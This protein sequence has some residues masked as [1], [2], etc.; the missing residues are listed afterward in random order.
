MTEHLEDSVLNDGVNG[1]RDAINFLQSLRAM[2]SGDSKSSK[3]NVTTK[4]DGAPAIFAGIN[5][6]NGKFFV[7]TKGV[8]AQNAKLNYTN[9]DIDANHPSEGLAS[10]LKLA[11][12][13]LAELN[14]KGVLQGDMMYARS[15]LKVENIDGE[16]LLT[17]QPNTITYAVPLNTTLAQQMLTSKLGIIW[18]T[19]YFGKKLEDTKASFGVDI[20]SLHR[21]PNVWFR[22]A[23]FVDV[24]GSAN[25]TEHETA[26][27]T[28]IL[29]QAGS[30]FRTI[31]PR[32]LNMIATNDTYKI[33]I[34]AWNNSKVRAGEK[35]TN[36]SAH[37]QGLIIDIENKLNKNILASKKADTHANRLKEKAIVLKFYHD[38]KIELKKIFDLQNLLVDAKLMVVRKLEQIKDIGTFIR[39]DSG[40]KVTA[41]EGFVAVNLEKGHATKLID[42]LEFSHANFNVAKNWG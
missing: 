33:A 26:K 10:K 3:I 16:K 12:Q 11:L 17:F 38:N 14:I 36:T 15:D 35:I 23:S 7:G 28:A 31:S 25:F 41:P 27:L 39:T 32:T 37:V 20:K 2:L 40:F 22:D 5:P 29:S 24:S 9:A 4:F 1:A 6:E 13:Y 18:H 34:K 42:R 30:L 21:T 19:S 8:F